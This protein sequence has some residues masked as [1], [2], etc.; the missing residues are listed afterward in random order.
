MKK[1]TILVDMDDTLE[2]LIEPWVQCLNEEHGTSVSVH[3]I[4]SWSIR[5]M[6]PEL[7]AQQVFAPLERAEFWDLVKPMDGAQEV[8][9]E[10]VTSGHKVKIVTASGHKTIEPK[11]E[12]VLFRHFPFLNWDD[13]IITSDKQMIK[14]DVLIDDAP[15]NLEGGDYHKILMTAP[16][17]RDYCAPAHGMHRVVNWSEVR[18]LVNQLSRENEGENHAPENP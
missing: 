15:H 12:R 7:T 11:M 6:Y 4:R 16:H 17:N 9:H 5:K 2:H 13:V 1:L 8:L 14:G 18:E 10:F 3:D